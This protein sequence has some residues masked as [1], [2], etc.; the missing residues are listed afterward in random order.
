MLRHLMTSWHLNMWKLKIW[1]SQQQK[2]LSK[3]NKKHFSLFHQ[4]LSWRHTKEISKNVA[5]T[6]FKCHPSKCQIWYCSNK[7]SRRCMRNQANRGFLK[8]FTKNCFSNAEKLPLVATHNQARF[9]CHPKS[10]HSI[11][12]KKLAKFYS[13]C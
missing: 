5:D 11:S 10:S 6:T 12:Q 2:E 7:C 4:V 3:W 1:L 8:L 9:G 13:K